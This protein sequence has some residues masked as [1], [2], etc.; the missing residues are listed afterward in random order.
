M[1]ARDPL[2]EF[3]RYAGVK[4]EQHLGQ[5]TR[6]VGLLADG[7]LWYRPN[8]HSNSIGNLLLHL[9]GNVRQ[10]IVAGV[11][12]TPFDRDRPA[13]FAAR[14]PRPGAALVADLRQTVDEA[15]VLLEKLDCAALATPRSIQG[16]NV[17]TLVAIFH[18]VEHFSFHTGQ[19]LSAT[20]LLRNVNLSLYDEQ[21]R[22]L[23]ESAQDP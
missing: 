17:C 22:K 14:G 21:G 5:I 16:Y 1:T 4:L 7:E 18:V 2:R 9:N 11:G 8:E 3:V 15:T 20:K 13:E 12:G 23:A 19:I 10:W 6:C